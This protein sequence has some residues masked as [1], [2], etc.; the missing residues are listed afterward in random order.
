MKAEILNQES[1]ED[2]AQDMKIGQVGIVISAGYKGAILLCEYGGFVNLSNP[3]Q[4][5]DD[6]WQG[7]V[8]ILPEGTQI[9]LTVERGTEVDDD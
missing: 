4:T 1:D 9:L 5:F 3:D 6:E 7:T 2:N 8:E